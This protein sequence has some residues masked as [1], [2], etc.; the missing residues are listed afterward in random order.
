MGEYDIALK[1]IL[2]RENSLLS[3]LIGFRVTRWL[4]GDLPEV[5]ISQVDLLGETDDGGLLHIELQSSNDTRMAARMLE[6]AV[7]IHRKFDRFPEQLV[8]YVGS[9]AMRMNDSIRGGGI[10][11]R[12]PIRNIRDLDGDAL[13]DS[14]HFGRQFNGDSGNPLR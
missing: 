1:N 2:M 12:C 4:S 9:Q 10:A 7:A 3:R 5:R 6:Y 11:F 14:P 13:L 8:L